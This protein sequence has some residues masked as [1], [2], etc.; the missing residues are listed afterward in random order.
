MVKMNSNDHDSNQS[1]LSL[2]T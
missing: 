1:E 2:F